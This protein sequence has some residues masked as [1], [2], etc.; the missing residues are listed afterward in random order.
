MS[1]LY[2]LFVIFIL[3]VACATNNDFNKVKLVYVYDGDTFKVNLPCR[4]DI[5]CK[6]IPVRIKGIDTAEIKTKNILEKQKAVCA[7]EFTEKLLSK[8]KISLK[9]CVR[10]KY[11]RL[12]CDVFIKNKKEEINLAEQL[13]LF[14]LASKYYG[15]TKTE[16]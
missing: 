6:E 1:K 4:K 12:L 9:T 7:K 13:L 10:D 5:F 11:F 2:L 8:G 16:F 14:N 15:K 3:C